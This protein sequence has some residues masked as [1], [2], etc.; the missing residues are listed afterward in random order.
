MKPILFTLSLSTLFCISACSNESW[1]HG[2][3]SSHDIRCQQES[4]SDY[5]ACKN[6]DRHSYDEYKQ[7]KEK[8]ELE[9]QKT[10]IK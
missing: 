9:Q 5:E 1:Y 8:L 7:A 2:S 6:E 4:I 3:V 10:E